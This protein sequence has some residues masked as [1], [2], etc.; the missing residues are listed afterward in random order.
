[1]STPAMARNNARA[2]DLPVR[3][4]EGESF[5]GGN[6]SMREADT[7]G[8]LKIGGRT[9]ADSGEEQKKLETQTPAP[10]SRSATSSSAS[11]VHVET[12]AD[13]AE[14]AADTARGPVKQPAMDLDIATGSEEYDVPATVRE[15]TTTKPM[16]T[17]P[18]AVGL[19]AKEPAAVEPVA[20][21]LPQLSTEPAPIVALTTKPSLRA[22][23]STTISDA[24]AN[25]TA[26]RLQTTGYLSQGSNPLV[27]VAL[28]G[29]C[30]IFL[31]VWGRKRRLRTFSSS[32]SPGQRGAKGTKLQYTQ[33][34]DEQPF[35]RCHD[36]DDEYC[37]DFEE[38]SFANDRGSWDDWESNATQ[39]QLN[40][41]ASAGSPPRRSIAVPE[42][43]LS[44]FGLSQALSPSPQQHV[45]KPRE[46]TVAG[47]S[48]TLCESD[49]SNSSSD[50]F[51]VVTDEERTAPASTRNSIT[52]AEKKGESA[53]DLFSQFNMVPTFQKSAAVPPA[54][55]DTSV[56]PVSQ[57]VSA[58]TLS[59]VSSLPT[60]AE[61][62]ALFAAEMDD[63]VT[64]VDASDEWDGD[65]E[66]IKGI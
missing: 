8:E 26:K 39:A 4:G 49:E 16:I 30:C 38:G 15:K 36:D 61:A 31:F 44:P 18:A 28:A 17:K 6:V 52:E 11:A 46:S 34:P 63:E 24:V 10:M 1:M 20:T 35:D 41:F 2:V 33:V 32:G 13:G 25:D 50:S 64:A 7:A 29:I 40:P 59:S 14:E 60:A 21:K 66:W 23:D 12:I 19:A 5:V 47:K 57:S 55:A 43:N 9:A 3:S 54:P 65:D 62:S 42:S 27:L 37:D 51:E 45:Q 53:D 56:A 22:E 48:D 58:A